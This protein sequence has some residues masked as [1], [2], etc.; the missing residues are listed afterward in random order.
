MLK[1][2][3]CIVLNEHNTIFARSGPLYVICLSLGPTR[4]WTQ[5]VSRS[6][7]NFLEQ[8]C[9]TLNSYCATLKFDDALYKFIHLHF[10][11]II[12]L[13]VFSRKLSAASSNCL[14][15]ESSGWRIFTIY[16]QSWEELTETLH[17]W[18][19]MSPVFAVERRAMAAPTTDE[20]RT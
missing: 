17:D 14:V 9:A 11:C 16:C 10:H 18:L 19:S 20:H 7:Q 2:E 1:L 3:G 13:E 6:L 4:A 12:L 15:A 8:K 5:T